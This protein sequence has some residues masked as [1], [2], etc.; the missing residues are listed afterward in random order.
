[1][2]DEWKC[3]VKREGGGDWWSLCGTCSVRGV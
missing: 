3:D 1:M 2:L